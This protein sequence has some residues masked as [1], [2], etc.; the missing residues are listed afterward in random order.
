MSNLRCKVKQCMDAGTDK[1]KMVSSSLAVEM[2]KLFMKLANMLMGR[3]KLFKGYTLLAQD[4]VSIDKL[5]EIFP[6]L[7]RKNFMQKCWC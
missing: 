3:L 4:L 1:V 7:V 6:I 2:L 5:A